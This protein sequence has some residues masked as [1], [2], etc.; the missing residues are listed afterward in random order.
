[1]ANA[2]VCLNGT[3]RKCS[4]RLSNFDQT[5]KG[6]RYKLTSSTVD[7]LGSHAANM[8]WSL[9]PFSRWRSS[10][11]LHHL[12]WEVTGSKS[13]ARR[14]PPSPSGMRSPRFLRCPCVLTA[15]RVQRAISQF[16]AWRY[17]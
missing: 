17:M 16:V 4:S 1:L 10:L 3:K 9:A 12:F 14:F 6:H 8:H 7:P 5:P 13:P 11:R 15:G 2:C